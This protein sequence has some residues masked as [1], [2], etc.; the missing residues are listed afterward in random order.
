MSKFIVLLVPFTQQTQPPEKFFLE[1]LFLEISQNSQESTS[2]R[3]P[4]L[5]KLQ[6][7]ACNFIK[8][9]VQSLLTEHL[10]TNEFLAQLIHEWYQNEADLRCLYDVKDKNS[11]E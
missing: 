1:K 2:A 6:I 5:I 7:L 11:Q 8:Q 10:R 4:C 3:V 9:E